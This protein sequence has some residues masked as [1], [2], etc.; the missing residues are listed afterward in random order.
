[1][2]G[3]TEGQQ[4][5]KLSTAQW[6]LLI[7][8][9]PCIII[10]AVAY[11]WLKE[12]SVHPQPA[13]NVSKQTK[14]VAP[15]VA[16]AHLKGGSHRHHTKTRKTGI[17]H[18]HSLTKG[19]NS[20]KETTTITE[21]TAPLKVPPLQK[22]SA[23]VTEK[24]LL[25]AKPKSDPRTYQ[26]AKLS[27]GFQVVNVHDPSATTIG[28]AVS[29]QAGSLNNPKDVLG[30]AH[31]CEHMVFLGT[32]NFPDP[33]SFDQFINKYGGGNNAY[34]SD[35]ETV[36]YLSTLQQGWNESLARMS[37]FFRAPLFDSTYVDKE[38]HAIESEHAKNV[39]NPAQRTYETM[40]SLADPRS[41]VSWFSTGDLKTLVIEPRKK[42]LDPVEELK[43]FFKAHYCPGKLGVV[44][45]SSGTLDAQLADT[46][47]QFGDIPEGSCASASASQP[48][49]DAWHP[50]DAP[51]RVGNWV[52]LQAA[53][54]R[55][56]LQ[57]MFP[58]D[59]LQMLYKSAPSEYMSYVLTWP[60]KQSLIRILKDDTGLVTRANVE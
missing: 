28:V 41:P 37:D 9:F 10:T 7:S 34:T 55:S 59:S 39:Q 51:A 26:Y 32:K 19:P 42:G 2:A 20:Q 3:P 56:Q 15:E 53:Q 43:K 31:F 13:T 4:R 5:Q 33:S 44:T 60:G 57:V 36:Y 23:T 45:Y 1:M 25:T 22:E 18:D 49:V 27:N 54:A 35:Q 11:F 40:L 58:M 30:L 14:A 38:V 29:V 8:I 46:L 50:R 17:E 12:K 24:K 6:F 52:H 21:D 47:A 48:I 16:P